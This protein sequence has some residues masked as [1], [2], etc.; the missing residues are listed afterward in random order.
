MKTIRRIST[1]VKKVILLLL[2]LFLLSLIACS[3]TG[4]DRFIPSTKGIRYGVSADGTYAEVLGYSGSATKI[5]IANTYNGLPV[6]TISDS[7]FWSCSNLTSVTIPDSV[8]TIGACAFY[9]CSNLTSVTIPDSVTTI[10]SGVFSA[11]SNLTSVYYVGTIVEWYGIAID[12]Y[13]NNL[14]D[15]TCYYYSET[16]PITKGNFWRYVEGEIVVW[17]KCSY[18]E[19]LVFASIGDG[20]C[21][22]TGIGT[23]TDSELN[24]PPVSSAGDRVTAIGDCAFYHCTNLT[25]VTIPNS[26]TTIGDYAFDSCSNLTSVT[27]PDSVTYIGSA[28][29]YECSNLTSITVDPDNEYYQSID[30]NLYSKDGKTL[31][32]YAIGK[33]QTSFTIPDSVTTIGDDA[34]WSCSKLTSV[35]IP[36]SVTTIGSWA[37]AACSNLTSVT[38]P[39]SVTTI[40]K[41]AFRYC[42]KL[43]SVSFANTEG[44]W[45]KYYDDAT[46]VYEISAA[47]LADAATAADYLRWTYY[48]YYWYCS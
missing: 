10:G 19:G 29:F 46:R 42:S 21:S 31:I 7:A 32:Q 22:V 43:T 28:A 14:T 13:N 4:F 38:I 33:T 18:S 17:P 37:F 2:S 8:T 27:I 36:D 39:D 16:E 30:G 6:T 45:V 3:C 11:C 24:I 1:M 25:S 44:W 48:D 5:K 20:V 35:N 41:Y 23:C 9:G 40:G 34:F 15:A 47:D 12:S 26:V